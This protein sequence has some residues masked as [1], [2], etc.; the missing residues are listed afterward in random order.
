MRL[1]RLATMIEIGKAEGRRMIWLA[2][3]LR[4]QDIAARGLCSGALIGHKGPWSL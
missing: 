1:L 2:D 3:V 4:N